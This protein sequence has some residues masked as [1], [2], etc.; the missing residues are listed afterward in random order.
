MYRPQNPPPRL[1]FCVESESEV[2][3][4]EFRAPGAKNNEKTTP[5]KVFLKY[6]HGIRREAYEV[7]K[8]GGRGGTLSSFYGKVFIRS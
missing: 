8:S 5:E 3:N 7:I 6:V 1:K 4:A 2:Q